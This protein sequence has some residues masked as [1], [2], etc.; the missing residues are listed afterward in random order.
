[1]LSVNKKVFDM[2]CLNVAAGWS[3]CKEISSNETG[4]F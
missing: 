1:M 3:G 2:C 4:D